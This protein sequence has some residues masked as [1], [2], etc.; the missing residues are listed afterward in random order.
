MKFM[1]NVTGELLDH[2]FRDM[3]EI[4]FEKMKAVTIVPDSETDFKIKLPIMAHP[5]TSMKK[6]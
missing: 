4:T 6:N 2:L 5:I 3:M 1:F